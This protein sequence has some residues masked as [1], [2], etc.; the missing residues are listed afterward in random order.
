[1]TIVTSHY[2][3]KKVLRLDKKIRR[4]L[5]SRLILF[6]ANPN[7]PLL[8]NHALTADR[9]EQRSINV[10]GNWRAVFKMLAAETAYFIDVDTHPHLYGD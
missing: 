4:A 10:T 3:D 2:F 5:E 1:M 8:N 6:L 7:H 9:E